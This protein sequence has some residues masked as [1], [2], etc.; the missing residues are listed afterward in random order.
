MNDPSSPQWDRPSVYSMGL[1]RPTLDVF[2]E[3]WTAA[4]GHDIQITFAELA[5]RL[6]VSLA[7]VQK[8]VARLEEAGAVTV[9]RNGKRTCSYQLN[10]S[11]DPN[12]APD[13]DD[14]PIVAVSGA[15]VMY[16]LGV[17]VSALRMP[18]SVGALGCYMRLLDLDELHGGQ[19]FPMTL[20]KLGE[21]FGV[22]DLEQARMWLLELW[23]VD[24]VDVELINDNQAALIYVDTAPEL[25]IQEA[26]RR[27]KSMRDDLNNEA[28]E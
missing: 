20:I 10:V 19:A 7:T 3:L 4:A 8:H 25:S 23:C 11:W 13:E 17:R 26:R 1:P 9:H 24:M 27:L 6:S 2:Q 15:L 16:G 22:D 28:G 14:D 5:R 12:D 21:L 18:I